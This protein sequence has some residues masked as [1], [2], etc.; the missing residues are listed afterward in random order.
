YRSM[1]EGGEGEEEESDTLHT[2]ATTWL[3]T[4]DQLSCDACR[5]LQVLSFFSP[6][7]LP[8]GLFASEE[9]PALLEMDRDQLSQAF[10]HLRRFSMLQ[11]AD[12]GGNVEME[13]SMHR[14]VGIVTRARLSDEETVDRRVKTMKV[15]DAFIRRGYGRPRDD[16]RLRRLTLPHLEF[17]L[18]DSCRDWVG[19]N[20]WLGSQMYQFICQTYLDSGMSKLAIP[21][22]HKAFRLAR[23]LYEAGNPYWEARLRDVSH[24]LGQAYFD[25]AELDEAEFYFRESAKLC[26]RFARKDR[27]NMLAKL[28]LSVAYISLGKIWETRGILD[29]AG[30][31]Y[32]RALRIDKDVAHREP[33]NV[34]A[35]ICLCTSLNSVGRIYAAGQNWKRARECHEE[36]LELAVAPRDRSIALINLARALTGEGMRPEA[37][38]RFKEAAELQRALANQ[39]PD[40]VQIKRDV[41]IALNDVG[42]D[43]E[44]QQ[45]WDKAFVYFRESFDLTNE[46]VDKD[47][48]NL[49]FIR[50]MNIALNSLGRVCEGKEEWE[51][52]RG[53]YLRNLEICRLLCARNERNEK[54][55]GELATSMSCLARVETHLKE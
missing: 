36:A 38:T 28:D 31:F 17:V 48:E 55:K 24:A 10:A 32:D 7:A 14:L 4:F 5:L 46:L 27:D 44:D 30:K 51:E 37:H 13:G 8:R 15:A 16:L 11:T 22:G 47:S 50:D 2:V 23:D 6:E 26:C 41:A 29:R 33:E 53:Y 20:P 12:L 43:W 54:A 45:K 52:A 18:T 42:K 19:Q 49:E 21:A 3:T 25:R 1:S 35:K 9:T 40:S 39:D 34:K